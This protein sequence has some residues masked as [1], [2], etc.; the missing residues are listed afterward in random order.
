MTSKTGIEI[1]DNAKVGEIFFEILL[2]CNNK[3]EIEY[4]KNKLPLSPKKFYFYL[5]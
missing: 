1:N 3:K 2:S 5:I 4:P